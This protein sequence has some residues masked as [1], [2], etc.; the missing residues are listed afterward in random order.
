MTEPLSITAAELVADPSLIGDV[1]A[2]RIPALLAQVTATAAALAARMPAQNHDARDGVPTAADRLLNADE[3][4]A[5]TGMSVDFLRRS[6]AAKP[7][8]VRVGRE[9]RFSYLAIQRYISRHAGRE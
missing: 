7:W 8:R 3:A 4:K 6:G 1:S 5:L 9:L 2:D